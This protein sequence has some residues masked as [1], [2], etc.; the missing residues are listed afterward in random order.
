MHSSSCELSVAVVSTDSAVL[1][2]LNALFR[3]FISLFLCIQASFSC[4][5]F[6]LHSW[7]YLELNLPRA[8]GP[9]RTMEAE[10]WEDNTTSIAGLI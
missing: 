8:D 3:F 2:N 5:G 4:W 6:A 1:W 9:A 10:V 7:L